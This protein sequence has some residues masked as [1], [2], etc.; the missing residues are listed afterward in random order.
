MRY[1]LRGP[2]LRPTVVRCRA[3]AARLL[4]HW[5]P[6]ARRLGPTTV[7]VRRFLGVETEQLRRGVERSRTEATEPFGTFPWPSGRVRHPCLHPGFSLK[8]EADAPDRVVSVGL[9][10]GRSP[11]G[12][13]GRSQRRS[14]PGLALR[15]DVARRHAREACEASVGGRRR[16]AL[17]PGPDL[18]RDPGRPPGSRTDWKGVR[19]RWRHG[20]GSDRKRRRPFARRGGGSFAGWGRRGRG[21]H[22]V[23]GRGARWASGC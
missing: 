2:A 14:R 4:V 8:E 15:L 22:A 17:A 1:P 10:G 12:K 3:S 21:S 23:L 20:A 6:D 11:A 13:L 16:D 19:D 5:L 9:T 7:R 18:S